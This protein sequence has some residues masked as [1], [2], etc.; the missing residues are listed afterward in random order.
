MVKNY[1]FPAIVC[2]KM[3]NLMQL[4]KKKHSVSKQFPQIHFSSTNFHRKMDGTKKKT[5]SAATQT[6]IE[7][8][9]QDASCN[10]T[11][12]KHW[13]K[14]LLEVFLLLYFIII[15]P[16][17][18]IFNSFKCIYYENV[19]PSPIKMSLTLRSLN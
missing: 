2:V 19:F 8:I 15:F 1:F 3:T 17:I 4:I 18:S 13:P 7:L 14:I 11:H 10:C 5:A 16:F 12:C 6:I 9:Q